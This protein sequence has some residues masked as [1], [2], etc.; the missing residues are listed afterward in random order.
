MNRALQVGTSFRNQLEAARYFEQM[1]QRICVGQLLDLWYESSPDISE[2]QYVKMV[3]L[4]TGGFLE[5]AVVIGSTLSNTAP[6]LA[7]RLRTYARSLGIAFQIYDD[8]LDL[9]PQP[10]Q[11]KPFASDIKRR[12]QRLPLVHFL[13]NCS[14]KERKEVRQSFREAEI[15]DDTAKELVRLM[16]ARGSIDY[17]L[18]R[19]RAFCSHAR[20]EALKVA[21]SANRDLLTGLV[22]LIQEDDPEPLRR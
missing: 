6:R 5:G 22:E 13:Q 19:A 4:T 20:S 11:I 14:P 8:V 18:C 1:Y 21:P 12:K 15:T 2:R 9:F 10:G 3:G 16:R 7:R 17:A